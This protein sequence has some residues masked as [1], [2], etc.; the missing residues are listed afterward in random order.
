MDVPGILF[1]LTILPHNRLCSGAPLS[2][3]YILFIVLLFEPALV[4][5]FPSFTTHATFTV[6]SLACSAGLTFYYDLF[7][8]YAT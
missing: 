4:V 8:R 5:P 6:H 7:T 2:F 3:S 1:H